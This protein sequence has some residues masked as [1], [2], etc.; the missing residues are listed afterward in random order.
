MHKKKVIVTM[1]HQG[2]N[3]NE[4]KYI[5]SGRQINQES[6]DCTYELRWK[7]YDDTDVCVREMYDA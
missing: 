3:E 6:T 2:Q 4:M 1:N 7:V 5:W